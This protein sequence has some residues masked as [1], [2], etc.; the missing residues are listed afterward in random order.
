MAREGVDIHS[1]ASQ[2]IYQ[3]ILL[4]TD[5]SKDA[6]AS[7]VHAFDQAVKYGATL[8]ILN[9]IPSINPCNVKI[10]ETAKSKSDTLNHS[11]ERDEK[12]RLQALGA[13]KKIYNERCR[14]VI[15][16]TFAVRV[17]SPD[18]EIIT[19]SEENDIDM[20]IMG[21][22]G[23]QETQRLTYIRTAA[24]VSKFANCQVIK[25]GSPKQNK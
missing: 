18:L 15:K 9:V 24:N 12:D 20:I 23:R 25:I 11:K 19:Y 22:A 7:F 1:M 14:G 17:G 6:E 8:H 5:Y 13:L 10:F 16:Y 3:N 21:T 2:L 4:C